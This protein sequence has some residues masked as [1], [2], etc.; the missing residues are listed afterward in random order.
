MPFGLINAPIVFMDLMNRVFWDCLDRFIVVFIDDTLV[1]S[2][3]YEEHEQHL[4]FLLQSLVEKQLYAKFYKREF[5]LDQ[6]AFLSH[7]VLIDSIQ[8]DLR[9]AE[10]MLDWQRCK[11]TK[12]VQS[13]LGLASYYKRFVEGFAKLA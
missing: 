8:V 13:F 5:W 6:V 9:K 2:R 11:T 1:Y 12:K 3:T 4:R 7:V 10:T